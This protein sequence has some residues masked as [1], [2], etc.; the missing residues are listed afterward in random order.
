MNSGRAK[1]SAPSASSD[2]T[3][4][5]VRRLSDFLKAA[6]GLTVEAD[7]NYLLESRLRP[8]MQ[9]EG[10]GGFK[11]L[12][13]AI[14]RNRGSR[15]A[16]SVVQAMTINETHF[17]RDRLPF[18]ALREALPVLALRRAQERT[19][20][21][22]SSACSTGQELYS[23]AIVIEEMSRLFGGWQI[24]FVGTDLSD[25]VLVK[26]RKGAYSQFEVQRGLPTPLLLKYF[27]R[28]GDEWIITER[29]R[30]KARFQKANLL[31]DVNQLGRFDI[32]FCRNVLFY[33][34]P[35]TRVSILGRIAQVMRPDG[36]LALGA[37]EGMT[38][39]AAGFRPS[40][41]GSAFY[42]RSDSA[43]N[44]VTQASGAA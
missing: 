44:P 22:W 10:L 41:V 24:E 42:V 2:L 5:L 7:K 3:P 25:N 29:I 11:D 18:D 35:P 43:T 14:E 17:F 26:A 6:S 31:G 40:G 12:V 8:I 15:L 30:K 21:I 38:A 28:I 36:Y 9:R 34:E 32:V 27:E 33:F 19:L 20:R 4:L 39:L 37:A 13:E 1:Q 16:E 23:M